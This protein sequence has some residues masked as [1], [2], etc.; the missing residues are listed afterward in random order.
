M[1]LS[2]LLR[3]STDRKDEKKKI[4]EE[5]SLLLERLGVYCSGPSCL[6]ASKNGNGII[7]VG[8]IQQ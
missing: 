6:R 1:Y 8:N 7:K 3:G 4:R 5:S 2:Y